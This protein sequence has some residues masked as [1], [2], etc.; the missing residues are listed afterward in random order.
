M[1][2]IMFLL[3]ECSMISLYVC[4]I[5]ACLLYT[6]RAFKHAERLQAKQIILLGTSEWERGSVR[7][8]N[9]TS[10]EDKDILVD[11]LI[12]ELSSWTA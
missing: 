2:I 8:K 9:L 5:V 10:R 12:A 11:N 3:Y 4:I 7:V 6:Y 1:C